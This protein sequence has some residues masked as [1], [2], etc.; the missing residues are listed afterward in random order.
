[1]LLLRMASWLHLLVESWRIQKL[2]FP[3]VGDEV[4]RIEV[5]GVVVEEAVMDMGEVVTIADGLNT[6]VEGLQ[7]HLS[8]CS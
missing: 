7:L 5:V 6:G 3:V 2:S 8:A 4:A 1:M